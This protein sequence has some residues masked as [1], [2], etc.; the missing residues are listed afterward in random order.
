ML[1][2]L[3]LAL[4]LGGAVTWIAAETYQSIVRSRPRRVVAVAGWS[5][6]ALTV[7]TGMLGAFS[8]AAAQ[9]DFSQRLILLVKIVLAAISA[10]AGAL[11]L[12]ASRDRYRQSAFAASVGFALAAGV[13]GWLLAA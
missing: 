11:G 12:L 9:L 7:A 6:F 10:L 8:S 1:S 5:G 4:H 13:F 2:S 3:Q